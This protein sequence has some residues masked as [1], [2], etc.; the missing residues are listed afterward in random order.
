MKCGKL[1]IKSAK[2]RIIEDSPKVEAMGRDDIEVKVE[3][4]EEKLWHRIRESY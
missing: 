4:E 2:A 1:E 3:D